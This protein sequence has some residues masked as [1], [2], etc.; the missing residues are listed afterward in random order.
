[1]AEQNYQR[2]NIIRKKHII[3][4]LAVV[5]IAALTGALAPFKSVGAAP[6]NDTVIAADIS[7]QAKF[8]INDAARVSAGDGFIVTGS[9][10]KDGGISLSYFDGAKQCDYVIRKDID[11]DI[12]IPADYGLHTHDGYVFI[13]YRKTVLSVSLQ[14]IKSGEGITPQRHQIDTDIERGDYAA[15]AGGALF[16]IEPKLSGNNYILHRYQFITGD[17]DAGIEPDGDGLDLGKSYSNKTISFAALDAGSVVIIE[18]YKN[19]SYIDFATPRI[20]T[21]IFTHSYSGTADDN[22]KIAANGN[23]IV[24]ADATAGELISLQVDSAHAGGVVISPLNEYSLSA[25]AGGHTPLKDDILNNIGDITIYGGTLYVL[26]N[27]AQKVVGLSAETLSF[28]GYFAG[29]YSYDIGE[30]YDG[31]HIYYGGGFNAPSGI[32]YN[33]FNSTITVSDTGNNRVV[34]MDK[35]SGKSSQVKVD[36][37]SAAAADNQK[38]IYAVLDGKMYIAYATGDSGYIFE[39]Q[40]ILT[41]VTMLKTSGGGNIYALSQNILYACENGEAVPVLS[42]V[43]GDII[44]FSPDNRTGGFYVFWQQDGVFQLNVYDNSF[45]KTLQRTLSGA[46]ISLAADIFADFAGNIYFLWD[47]G[48]DVRLLCIDSH[49]VKD[50]GDVQVTN[51][52]Q[53]DIGYV[54][55]WGDAAVSFA[56]SGDGDLYLSHKKTHAVYILQRSQTDII[57]ENIMPRLDFPSDP[58]LL[59]DYA[60]FEYVKIA[61]Y[62]STLFYPFIES[63]EHMDKYAETAQKEFKYNSVVQIADTD[64]Y[65]LSLGSIDGYRLIIYNGEPGFI[66]GDNITAKAAIRAVDPT[67]VRLLYPANVYRQPAFEHSGNIITNIAEGGIATVAG[68]SAEDCDGLNYYLVIFTAD[69]VQRTGF[70]NK[71]TAMPLIS[72]PQRPYI[73]GKLVDSGTSLYSDADS[74]SQVLAHITGGSELFIYSYTGEYSYVAVSVGAKGY[75]GYILSA[76]IAQDMSMQRQRLG[77]ILGGAAIACAGI[78]AVLRRKFF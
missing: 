24:L 5:L 27:S 77:L 23:I 49:S 56:V 26:D 55:D 13:Y 19:F 40:H 12:N 54:P 59:D 21:D 3:C 36:A 32:S 75:T 46:D 15:A 38:N 45:N 6:E 39:N 34:I 9:A 58:L 71:D 61:G 16:I 11:S 4:L 42:D 78:F 14:D 63:V 69:G 67:D 29:A 70:I 73:T 31:E 50:G 48:S 37:P 47:D 60:D 1:M 20:D 66:L 17:M 53:V 8:F 22:N 65:Y 52:L 2:K 72:P 25:E 43:T 30:G 68:E 51:V 62:P 64:S 74:Q 10:A 76:T 33:N 41:D 18:N 7:G 57:T 28:N 44:S 35:Q